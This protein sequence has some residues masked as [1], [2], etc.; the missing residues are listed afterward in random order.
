MDFLEA[1]NVG[2][3][4][5]TGLCEALEKEG[6][7]RIWIFTSVILRE[8]PREATGNINDGAGLTAL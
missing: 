4:T 5:G 7:L 3:N 2:V 8:Q 6:V 1:L